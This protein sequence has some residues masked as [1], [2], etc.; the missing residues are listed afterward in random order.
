MGSDNRAKGGGFVAA[1]K[2]QAF[3]FLNTLTIDKAG[4]DHSQGRLSTV[5]HR[6]PPALARPRSVG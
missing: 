2:G 3:W 5:D 6:V 4:S 1:D